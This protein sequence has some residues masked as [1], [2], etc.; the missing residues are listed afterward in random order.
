M[1]SG[2]ISGLFFMV[3]T[4]GLLASSFRSI[5]LGIY[6][7]DEIKKVKQPA[8]SNKELRMMWFSGTGRRRLCNCEDIQGPTSRS[9]GPSWWD[10]IPL[11][12]RSY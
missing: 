10:Q 9:T 11:L 5:V 8:F 2:F 7:V 4:A 12:N 6:T 1:V 3:F